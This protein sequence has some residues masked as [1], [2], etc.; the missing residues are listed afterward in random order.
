MCRDELRDTSLII[1]S[2]GAESLLLFTPTTYHGLSAGVDIA[3]EQN[4]GISFVEILLVDAYEV[5]P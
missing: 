4:L 3:H 2:P 1:T 5:D